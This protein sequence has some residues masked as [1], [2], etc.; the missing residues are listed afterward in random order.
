MPNFAF[1]KIDPCWAKSIFIIQNIT[2]NICWIYIYEN[3]NWNL[4]RNFEIL[5]KWAKFW[6]KHGSQMLASKFQKI[7]KKFMTLA[8]Q[9]CSSLLQVKVLTSEIVRNFPGNTSSNFFKKYLKS[10]Y[11]RDFLTTQNF[12][13]ENTA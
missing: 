10:P 8:I 3:L 2:S 1:S 11:F 5:T 9:D 13:L 12:R 4:G 7:D 6:K